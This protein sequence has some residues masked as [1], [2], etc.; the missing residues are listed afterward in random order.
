MP[1][2]AAGQ[3]FLSIVRLFSQQPLVPA[4]VCTPADSLVGAVL[5]LMSLDWAGRLIGTFYRGFLFSVTLFKAS[6][7]PVLCIPAQKRH[8]T[9]DSQSSLA[10]QIPKEGLV[11]AHLLVT[12]SRFMGTN[13]LSWV[14]GTGGTALHLLPWFAVSRFGKCSLQAN[15]RTESFSP[16]CLWCR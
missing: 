9:E 6:S 1:P 4:P 2:A 12:V 3:A 13:P 14:Q 8:R 7:F 15:S 16:T 11:K 10:A 5:L